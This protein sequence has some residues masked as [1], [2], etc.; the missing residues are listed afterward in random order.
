MPT[1]VEVEITNG[2]ASV[3]SEA[4]TT[5]EGGVHWWVSRRGYDSRKDAIEELC[6]LAK[7]VDELPK[8]NKE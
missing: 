6:R 7:V 2:L 1:V 5:R 4:R 8:T 3:K